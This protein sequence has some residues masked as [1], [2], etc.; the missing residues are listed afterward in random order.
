MNTTNRCRSVPVVRLVGLAGA[1]GP[2]ERGPASGQASAASS[3]ARH[4]APAAAV[5]SGLI[6]QLASAAPGD[7]DPTFGDV[8]RA[9]PLPDF[10]GPAWSVE[11]HEDDYLF[12]GGDDYY[13]AFY[14]YDNCGLTNFAGRLTGTGALDTGFAAT[15]L[16]DTEVLDM[17][18]QPD[19]KLVAVGRTAGSASALPTVFRLNK[20]G[21]LDTTFGDG[22]IVR[23]A[24]AGVPQA[25][26]SVVIEPDGRLTVAGA[27]GGRVAVLRWL[28]TG[29]PDSSFGSGGLFLMLIA[30][31]NPAPARVVRV[32]NGGYRVTVHGSI[33]PPF[34][35]NDAS[36]HVVALTAAGVLDGGFGAAGAATVAGTTGDSITCTSIDVQADGRLMLAGSEGDQGFAMRLLADGTLDSS[37]SGAEASR[38]MSTATALAVGSSGSIVLAGHDAAG[39]PGS[40][41]VRLQADGQLDPAF[42]TAGSAWFELSAEFGNDPE[43]KDVDVLSGGTLL[44]AGAEWCDTGGPF[45]A[46][47]LGDGVG[48]GPGVLGIKPGSTEALEQDGQA[49]V[50]VRRIGGST[51]AVAVDYSTRTG[52]VGPGWAVV[53]E[54]FTAVQGRL[55]WLDGDTGEREVVVPIFVGGATPE[56]PEQF[57]VTLTNASGGAGLGTLTARVAIRG[58]GHPS[59]L[60]SIEGRQLQVV[61]G[62]GATSFQVLRN[63]YGSGRVSVT[64]RIA[65][66]SATL[67]QDYG[68]P[69]GGLGADQVL[70]WEDGDMSP[71]MV[72]VT[73]LADKRN[74]PDETFTASIT[75]PTGGAVLGTQT[76]VTATI[77]DNDESGGG[78]RIAGFGALLLAFG[79]LL[80]RITERSRS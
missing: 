79:G 5:T 70:T 12:A 16:A 38:L 2:V 51:G 17:A 66:G 1:T 8:G 56:G 39:L 55:E 74:E 41:V 52:G 10:W 29:A 49:V 48:G 22:G 69:A 50:T 9:H 27:D 25:F 80:R 44:L 53:G 54:D 28:A 76:S 11:A 19:G 63:F 59:G 24:A 20:D 65:N 37:F 30:G 60:F 21:T 35:A 36:C 71:R 58:D 64:V 72:M 75:S 13:C 3:L 46:R 62:K 78:G 7:L 18:V 26:Q 68:W 77:I 45:V 4:I 61:E 67:G 31:A 33:A 40:L 47:L 15:E 14:Y 57:D 32:A 73:S 6:C 43:I 34:D 42:G 23:S